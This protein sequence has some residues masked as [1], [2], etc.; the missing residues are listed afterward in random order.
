MRFFGSGHIFRRNNIHDI[1]IGY[2]I[3]GVNVNPDP[4]ID[5]FQTWGTA[6]SAQNIIF[7]QNYCE[8]LND[9]MFVFMID[10]G[11]NHII[12]RNNI[13]LA[14]GGIDAFASGRADYLYIYNNLWAGSGSSYS[15]GVALLL[16]DVPHAIIKNNIM[17]N[18]HY[19]TILIS[20]STAGIDI[21]FNLAYNSNGSAAHCID[22]GGSCKTSNHDI[23]NVSPQF[24]NPSTGDYHLKS[25]SPAINAGETVDVTNDYEGNPR[26]QGSSY[27]IGVYEYTGAPAPTNTPGFATSTPTPKAN[28]T[29]TRTA[30]V[31]ANS[32]PTRT[33]RYNRTATPRRNGDHSFYLPFVVMKR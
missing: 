21:G 30:T 31:K 12:I 27:D 9:G 14:T 4:H 28:S 10:G 11:S 8:N 3:N 25:N 22:F 7:E 26:P 19:D 5:C 29:P 17:Y 6:P 18:Q 24:V 13:F 32:T 33:P 15:Y 1:K 16:K 2:T 20:G 23:W